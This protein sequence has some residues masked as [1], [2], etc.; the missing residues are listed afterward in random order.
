MIEFDITLSISI[1]WD[2][3]YD[4]KVLIELV[5]QSANVIFNG[6]LEF[7]YVYTHSIAK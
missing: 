1:V 4:F 6:L 5:N 2:F 3:M 7:K